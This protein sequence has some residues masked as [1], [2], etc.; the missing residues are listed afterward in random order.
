[1]TNSRPRSNPCLGLGSSLYFL[2]VLKSSQFSI[3]STRK[4]L[5]HLINSHG[6]MLVRFRETPN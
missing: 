5:T 2:A 6:E 1:M 3:Y 4:A